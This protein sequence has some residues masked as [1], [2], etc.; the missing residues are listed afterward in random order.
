MNLL[1]GTPAGLHRVDDGHTELAGRQV[2]AL[3]G[4][5]ALVEGRAVWRNGEWVGDPL[6]GPLATCV[7]PLDGG[8]LVGTVE[9]HLVRLPTGE[10][11]ASFEDAP[12]REDWYT[13]WGGPADV[14]TMAAGPDGT[15]Y[16]NVHVGGILRSTNGG[17]SWEPTLDIDLDVHQVAV[18]EDGTVLAAT[19]RGLATSDDRG[20]SWT[21]VDAGL[22]ATYARAVA[23][24]GDTVLLSVSTG[25]D[26]RRA[27]VYRRPLHDG[28]PFR[29]SAIG[30]PGTFP[31]NVDTFCLA[32]A[33]PVAALGTFAGRV[34]LSD[35][36]GASWATVAAGPPVTCLT[37]V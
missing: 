10:R 29:R 25:P 2:N 8:A 13:P 35:D 18:A 37:L 27:A 26:G 21:V 14:R 6:E 28:G 17:A 1:V 5:L 33:G 15:L 20:D 7:L 30:L 22:A 23:V 19:A 4:D 3:A 31:G 12:G 24:A 16:V 36:A 9:G 11:L 32:G 34:Y